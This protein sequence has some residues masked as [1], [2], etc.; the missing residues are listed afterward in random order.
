MEK[1]CGID[2]TYSFHM[3]NELETLED[4]NRMDYT[5]NDAIEDLADLLD[6][7]DED[8]EP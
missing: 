3:S 6:D 2:N 1:L 8:D 7:G 5:D 4:N